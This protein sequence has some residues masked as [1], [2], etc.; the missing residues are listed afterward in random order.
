VTKD[1]SA[2]ALHASARGLLDYLLAHR[3]P[4]AR[5][6]DVTVAV[7][8]SPSP[9]AQD[10]L[11]Y[12]RLF[13]RL[14]NMSTRY[15]YAAIEDRAAIRKQDDINDWVLALQGDGPEAAARATARWRATRSLPWLVAALWKAPTDA[16]VVGAI[17]DA[18]GA[19]KPDAPGFHTVAVAR[20]RLLV[21]LGRRDD[22]RAVLASL[23]AD[24]GQGAD[25]ETINLIKALRLQVANSF[26]EFLVN[27]PR[28]S[29]AGPSLPVLD[30]DA[31]EIFTHHL[32]LDR[33]LEAAESATLPDRLRA[34]VAGAAVSRAIVTRQSSAGVRAARALRAVA[35]VETQ[36]DLDRYINAGSEDERHRRG[37]LLLARTPGLHAFVQGMEDDAQAAVTDPNRTFE[38]AW[39]RRNWWC[40]A[41]GTIGLRRA[42]PSALI[43]LLYGERRPSAAT[44]LQSGEAETAAKEKEQLIAIGP[45]HI[46]LAREA[47]ALA[48]QR[49]GD[50]EIAEMLAQ[51][52]EGGRWTMCTGPEADSASRQAFQTLHKIY[53]KSEWARRTRFWYRSLG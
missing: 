5:L 3:D 20:A 42:E 33:L 44:F 43:P 24:A 39:L 15:P 45:A 30:N 48:K 35:P 14:V 23:P 51:V 46:F 29:L 12:E 40:T 34:R 26:E 13:D 36:A 41:N 31:G 1:A 19:V 10:L 32:P 9:T 8:K 49:P 27:A 16:S 52:V 18:A 47:I 53:P 22:A 6:H 25:V 11:D 7:V 50:L 17:L 37:L 2:S 28:R 21:Q 4:V 38:Q